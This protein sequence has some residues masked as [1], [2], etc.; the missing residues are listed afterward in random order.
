MFIFKKRKT[1][2]NKL[3]LI[4]LDGV[5][6]NK[7]YPGNAVTL[8]NMPTFN[9]LRKDYPNMLLGA[10]EEYVGLPKKQMGSSEVGHFTLGAGRIVDSEIV[11][12]IKQLK[13]A[14]SIKMMFLTQSYKT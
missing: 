8:A 3:L 7:P 1:N 2:N 13:M 11:K 14:T 10:S 9:S 4:I 5:G 6:I 12:L